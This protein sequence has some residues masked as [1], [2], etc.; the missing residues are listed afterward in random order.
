MT[1]SCIVHSLI[2]L[3]I[4][5]ES[6]EADCCPREVASQE[7]SDLHLGLDRCMNGF[8][9]VFV[10]RASP[11]SGLY[12]IL[13]TTKDCDLDTSWYYLQCSTGDGFRFHSPRLV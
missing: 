13:F 12:Y 7:K 5:E 8:A 10:D 2:L 9:A 3:R 6:F 4:L 11:A 1:K